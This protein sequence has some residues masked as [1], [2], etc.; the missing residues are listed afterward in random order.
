V[1]FF[2]FRL[3]SSFVVSTKS[4]QEEN[5]TKSFLLYFLHFVFAL[6]ERE[7]IQEAPPESEKFFWRKVEKKS[8]FVRNGNY[9]CV[10]S[11][12]DIWIHERR[13]GP[14]PR[15]SAVECALI[16]LCPSK[17]ERHSV[18]MKRKKVVE[19]VNTKENS[20]YCDFQ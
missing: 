2:G 15:F 13:E 4:Y 9:V 18:V 8:S 1:N 3:V 11:S 10:M 6:C 12:F 14:S 5:E 17:K 16:F 20:C 7:T 19:K